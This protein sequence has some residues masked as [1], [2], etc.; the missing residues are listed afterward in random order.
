MNC[1][2]RAACHLKTM[3]KLKSV[4][5]YLAKIAAAAVSPAGVS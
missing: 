1:R 3:M 4:R 5:Q 2:R